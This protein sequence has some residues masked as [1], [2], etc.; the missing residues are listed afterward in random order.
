MHHRTVKAMTKDENRTNPSEKERKD[1]PG[2]IGEKRH[3]PLEVPDVEPEEFDI[4]K[5]DVGHLP[6]GQNTKE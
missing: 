3:P 6:Q 1:R 5:P 4:V 2:T